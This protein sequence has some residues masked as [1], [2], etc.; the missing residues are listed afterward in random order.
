MSCHNGW[1]TG[2][3]SVALIALTRRRGLGGT[4]AS[5][6]QTGLGKQGA[7]IVVFRELLIENAYVETLCG[8]CLL[9]TSLSPRD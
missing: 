5:S 9:Y 8:N 1:Q 4:A 3:H 2:W 7:E 6:I